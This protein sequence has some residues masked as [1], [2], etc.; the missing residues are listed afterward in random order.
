[1]LT[2]SFGLNSTVVP[3]RGLATKIPQGGAL[4]VW[5]W[6]EVD[7][8]SNPKAQ[9]S[10]KAAFSSIGKGREPESHKE[11]INSLFSVSCC[12]IF[13]ADEI[14]IAFGTRGWGGRWEGWVLH[15]VQTSQTFTKDQVPRCKTKQ[16]KRIF[17]LIWISKDLKSISNVSSKALKIII[18]KSNHSPLVILMYFCPQTRSFLNCCTGLLWKVSSTKVLWVTPGYLATVTKDVD[19]AEKDKNRW[20]TFW[21]QTWNIV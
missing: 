7:W 8:P 15:N 16:Q 10:F 2:A 12:C 19:E 20:C 17:L 13:K 4:L 18:P 9:A 14:L 5:N 11:T 21:C 6:T 3:P 1:M